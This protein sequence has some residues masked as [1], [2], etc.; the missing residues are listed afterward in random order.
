[1]ELSETLKELD[2][3]ISRAVIQYMKLANIK[4]YK[5]TAKT[6]KD[7][8]IKINKDITT[9]EENANKEVEK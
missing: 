4:T 7:G 6:L 9:F 1:M 3:L 2:E 8:N 5:F